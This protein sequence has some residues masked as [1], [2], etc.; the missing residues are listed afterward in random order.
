MS[1]PKPCKLIGQQKIFNI[2]ANQVNSCCRA[3]PEE[4]DSN[5]TIDDYVTHWQEQKLLL[6]QGI[7]LPQ[8][9]ICWNDEE[10]N[11]ISYRQ[12]SLDTP[13]DN[14]FELW[15]SNACNQMCSYCS[16]KY[17]STWQETIASNGAFKYIS[18]SAQ[19]N[20]QIPIF[21]LTSEEHWLESLCQHIK[22][23]P[24]NSVTIRLLGGEP[25]MQRNSLQKMLE[26]D[27]DN[28]KLLSIN[29]NLNPPSDKFLRWLLLT[30][31]SEKLGFNVSIDASPLYNYVPRGKFDPDEFEK[32]LKLVQQHKINV[33]LVS[34]ISVLSIFDL[35]NFIKW[36]KSHNLSDRGF[37]K[38][39]HPDCLDPMLVPLDFRKRIWD[40]IKEFDMPGV[41]CE[42]LTTE[43]NLSELRLFEQYIYLTQYFKHVNIDV[44]GIKNPLFIEYW[45]W[46]DSKYSKKLSTLL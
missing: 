15:L 27:V 30:I 44:S 29:T 2:Y 42:V 8:C 33:R 14:M 19:Q 43:S 3:Y 16:P 11:K 20:Q 7:K 12:Q 34:T 35:R 28:I 13:V 22:T 9:Q 40:S 18:K 25:L 46:L 26:F 6:A 1:D 38:I 10:Q 31:P 45:N 32:N 39:N 36:T 4:L 21:S 17:S 41:I 23:Y 5:K 37:F 24:S